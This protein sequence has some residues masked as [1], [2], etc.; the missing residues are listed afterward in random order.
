MTPRSSRRPLSIALINPLSDFGIDTYTYE[1]GQ[2][3]AANGVRVDSYCSAASHIQTPAL[4]ANHRRLCVLG[5]R[6]PRPLAVPTASVGST[7]PL[8]HPPAVG[9]SRLPAWFKRPLRAPMLS[10]ELSIHLKRANYDVVWTQWP[11]LGEYSGFWRLSRW[12][13]LTV[14][15]TVHN[16]LPHERY[17]D[18]V[19]AYGRV[20]STA[21]LLF[22]HSRPVRDEL[23]RL[24]PADKA[25]IVVA[26]HGV[27]TVFP[28][29][30]GS[31]ERLRASL[32]IPPDSIVL[33]FCGGIRDYKNID[34]AIAA[35]GQIRSEKVVL[36]VA[37]WEPGDTSNELPRTR[38][39]IR[40]AG[41]ESRSRLVPGFLD[42][43]TMA[44]VFEASDVL[45]LPYRKSYGSG[46]LMLG[47]TFGKYVVATAP[48][49]EEAASQYGRA[50]LLD[51]DD[52]TSVRKGIERAI[53]LARC[54][55][56]VPWHVPPE[57]NWVNIA[58]KSL[59]AI[60]TALSNGK[61]RQNSS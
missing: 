27:Y 52:A 9:P 15:H 11:E 28:R 36:V 61:R 32:N 25:H 19:A 50:I 34:A 10:G 46:L 4:H 38:A 40:D 12:L 53:E 39:L 29:R 17:H 30:S 21:R 58:A 51:G 37:G 47:I 6:L 16:V 33:L 13:G 42:A 8:A 54:E 24:F 60:E 20:Y 31:R 22:V 23:A 49:M 41:V 44:D 1:L 55:P 43:E 5:G 26:P 48:G 18:D 56:G 2:G 59:D 14:V 3:L 35:F 7:T 57:F 45:L